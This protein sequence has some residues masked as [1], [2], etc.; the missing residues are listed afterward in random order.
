[1]PLISIEELAATLTGPGP[2][3]GLDIGTKTIGI[4]VS[5]RLRK[6]ATA[7]TLIRRRK[8]QSDARLLL[9]LAAT[10]EAAGFVIGH[11]LNMDASEGPR[12]Q[13]S[14]AFAG[15]LAKLTEAPLTLW[16]ERLSTRAAE[17]VLIASN[18]SRVRRS[19]L[20][21]KVAAAWILQAVL[22]R[23]ADLGK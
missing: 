5:D 8:F 21:D 22:D 20:I 6:I 3:I 10:E 17:R 23:L 19:Q 11:P 7:R 18:A 1:M 13:S 4:A 9:D 2:L 15:N 12:A 16:D 14:R